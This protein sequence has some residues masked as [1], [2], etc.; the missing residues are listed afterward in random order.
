QTLARAF[1]CDEILATF[2]QKGTLGPRFKTAFA[3]GRVGRYL[4]AI[5]GTPAALEGLSEESSFTELMYRTITG[6]SAF[7]RKK[8]DLL[9]AMAVASIDHGVTPPSAQVAII[10]ASTRADYAVSVASGVGAITDVHG[11]AGKKAALFYSE[12]LSRSK[13][14]G[15]DLE[16]ATKAVVTEYVRDG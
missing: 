3:L 12:C 4:A 9:E 2:P 7:D 1:L 16:E 13:R 10:S 11:G 14:T 6:N 15:L 8:A 5:L